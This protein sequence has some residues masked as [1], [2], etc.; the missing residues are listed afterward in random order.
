MTAYPNWHGGWSLGNRYLLPL[1]FP[2]GFRRWR[3]RSRSPLSRWWLRRRGASTRR[4]VHAVLS[5][6]WP[7][8]PAE[9][10]WPL[11]NGAL[12]FLPPADGR[13]PG[14][15]AIPRSGSRRPSRRASS[16]PVS[17]SVSPS[18][19][20]GSR[21]AAPGLAAAAGVVLFAASA[22]APPAAELLHARVAG[23]DLRDRVRTRSFP[24]GAAGRSR[25][26]GDARGAAGERTYYRRRYR[27]P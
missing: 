10:H 23:G 11:K 13:R 19:P 15:S 9:L 16:P 22:T 5:S 12:W 20:P 27:L 2:G 25:G 26:S 8:F 24:R 6:A 7:H 1:L 14:S 3:T 18:F 21:G 4:R 17:R